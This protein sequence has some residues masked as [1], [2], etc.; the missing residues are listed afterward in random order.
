MPAVKICGVTT[1]AALNAALKGG[2]RF[3]GLVFFPNSPRNLSVS[4]GARL[5]ARVGERAEVVA[6]TVDAGDEEL[7]QLA[8]AVRPHWIQ[9]HGREDPARVQFVR[10]FARRGAI[11]AIALASDAD[12]TGAKSFEPVADML[13]FDAKPPRGADRPGGLGTA[14]DW[15]IL[16]GREISRSWF[17]SGGLTPD[18]VAEAARISGAPCVDASSGLESAPGVKDPLRI[19]AFLAAAHALEPV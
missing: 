15:R 13:L 14:F 4:D 16:A 12:L 5:A 11:K 2:A 3:V 1:E 10:R 7:A 6:V 8:E 18:N 19:A 17:L 9:L